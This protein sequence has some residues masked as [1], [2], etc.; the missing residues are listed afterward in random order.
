[1]AAQDAGS[2]IA[3]FIDRSQPP[4]QR[5]RNASAPVATASSPPGATGPIEH[6]ARGGGGVRRLAHMVAARPLVAVAM[7]LGAVVAVVMVMG[8]GGAPRDPDLP[9]ATVAAQ[10]DELEASGGTAVHSVGVER[11]SS[12][13]GEAGG[14]VP[15]TASPPLP[16]DIVTVH[17]AG[18]VAEP[19]VY[20]LPAGSRAHDAIAAAGGM[21]PNADGNRL[22]LAES[23]ADGVRLYVPLPGEEVVAIVAGPQ[24]STAGSPDG[25]GAGVISLSTASSEQLQTL[26]GVGPSTA[27]AIISHRDEHGPFTSVDALLE[28]RG[29]GPAKLG[30]IR[31]RVV[32]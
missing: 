13:I 1:V 9:F 23:L 32:P 11:S 17:V 22:N 14:I 25:T 24:Q 31:D 27:E 26:S 21:L 29:I 18:A 3:V 10:A 30:A 28:V 19:G 8:A 6:L 20:E 7:A 2:P 12:L 4:A 15:G 5:Y 16:S